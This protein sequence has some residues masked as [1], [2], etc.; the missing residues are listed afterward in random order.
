MAEQR[1]ELA[2]L[3]ARAR[4]RQPKMGGNPQPWAQPVV[5][6]VQVQVQYDHPGA[7]PDAFPNSM[8]DQIDASRIMRVH[9]ST[10][11]RVCGSTQNYAQF[12]SAGAAFDPYNRM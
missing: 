4:A 2:V 12:R 3:Q 9:M 11:Q 10:P 6:P 5:V 7:N 8:A 1:D